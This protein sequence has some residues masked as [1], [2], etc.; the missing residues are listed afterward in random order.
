MIRGEQ[1]MIDSET[2][3]RYEELRDQAA[4]EGLTSLERE[5]LEALSQALCREEDQT[6]EEAAQRMR[7]ETK[8]L[9]AELHRVQGQNKQLEQALQ[10]A[11]E[12]LRVLRGE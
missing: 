1:E 2:R 10:R 4:A 3:E 7:E 8:D 11:E 12:R 9:E 5:E 6:L